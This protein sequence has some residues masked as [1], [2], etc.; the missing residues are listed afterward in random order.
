MAAIIKQPEPEF[1]LS[2]QLLRNFQ[3]ENSCEHVT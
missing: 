1:E 2:K 3:T